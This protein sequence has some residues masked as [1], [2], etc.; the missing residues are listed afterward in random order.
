EDDREL[1]LSLREGLDVA[2]APDGPD[3]WIA[4]HASSRPGTEPGVLHFD[5]T[6]WT[7]DATDLRVLDQNFLTGIVATSKT[8]L[9]MVGYGTSNNQSQPL[10]AH[11]TDGTTWTAVTGAT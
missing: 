1:G 4:G 2:L 8:D 6:Q 7:R 11:S 9:W 5:G 3:A 10:L